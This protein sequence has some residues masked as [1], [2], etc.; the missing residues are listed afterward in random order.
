MRQRNT[1]PIQNNAPML[2][3]MQP[4][5]ITSSP[6][7][8][9]ENAVTMPTQMST[10]PQISKAKVVAKNPIPM[11]IAPTSKPPRVAKIGSQTGNNRQ[12][13]SIHAQTGIPPGARGA[14]GGIVREASAAAAP[15]TACWAASASAK[16]EAATCSGEPSSC[17]TFSRFSGP[18]SSI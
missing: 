13:S 6:S 11:P 18:A 14:G 15:F 7:G 2:S 12:I 17:K 9:A 10:T 16:I 8:G 5:P 1:H 4:T 3:P